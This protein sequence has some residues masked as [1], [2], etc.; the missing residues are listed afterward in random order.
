V[1]NRSDYFKDLDEY[2]FASTAEVWY[3]GPHYKPIDKNHNQLGGTDLKQFYADKLTT[4]TRPSG[5]LLF[6]RVK[7]IP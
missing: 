6:F 7:L 1:A 4:G 3:F 2:P 5:L